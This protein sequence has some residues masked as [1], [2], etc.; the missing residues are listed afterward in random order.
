LCPALASQVHALQELLLLL[1]HPSTEARDQWWWRGFANLT[2][3]A[4]MWEKLWYDQRKSGSKFSQEGECHQPVNLRKECNSILCYRGRPRDT[5]CPVDMVHGSLHSD[6]A[7]VALPWALQALPSNYNN[8]SVA[9]TFS[10][11]LWARH[12]HGGQELHSFIPFTF[13]RQVVEIALF[14]F[15]TVLGFELRAYTLSHSTSPFLWWIFF[16]I[17]SHELLALGWL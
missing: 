17:G 4:G 16:E 11:W 6:L 2:L 12:A 7:M 14:F 13:L 3:Y 8:F 5:R 15:F 1:Q 9:G 10:P